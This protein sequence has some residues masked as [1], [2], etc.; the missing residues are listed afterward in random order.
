[1]TDVLPSTNPH[2]LQLIEPGDG[3]AVDGS[4]VTF[5]WTDSSDA[6]SY[7]LQVAPDGDFSRLH[8]DA[9]VGPATSITLYD[10]FPPDGAGLFW[11]VAA[12]GRSGV[13]S[14]PTRSIHILAERVSSPTAAIETHIPPPRDPRIPSPVDPQDGSITDGFATTFEWEPVEGATGYRLQV[15]QDTAFEDLKFDADLG[16]AQSITLYDLLPL[17]GP[18]LRWRVE[19]RRKDE[20]ATWSPPA[21]FRAVSN[22]AEYTRR[23]PETGPMRPTTPGADALA[24]IS[25]TAG[26]YAPRSTMGLVALW[27]AASTALALLIL[28]K[29]LLT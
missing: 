22:Y 12:V 8:I 16:R 5:E 28:L 29:L 27:I 6:S 7:R 26:T 13:V 10:V 25:G 17:D 1:M 21:R 2:N 11:R 20:A 23:S 19:A 3:A 15:A 4:A 9:D 24:A 14:S 18:E